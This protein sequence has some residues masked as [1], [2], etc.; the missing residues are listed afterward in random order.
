MKVLKK[1]FIV[2]FVGVLTLVFGNFYTAGAAVADV[3]STD[4]IAAKNAKL[5][6]DKRQLVSNAKVGDKAN[7][8]F[9]TTV[10]SLSQAGKVKFEYDQ[11]VLRIDKKKYKFHNGRTQV[12]VDIDGKDS[13]IQWKHAVGRTDLEVVLPVKFNQAVDH[14][15]L[16]FTVD[17]REVKLPTLTVV[18]KDSKKSKETT[19]P[20]KGKVDGNL[21]DDD[22]VN[23]V[24]AEAE[25]DEAASDQAEAAKQAEDA[26][27]QAEEAK[28]QADAK[29][30]EADKKEEAT[31]Q[32]VAEEPKKEAE[33][34]ENSSQADA[35][36]MPE[37]SD[38]D[39]AKE[40]VKEKR[41]AD[42]KAAEEKSRQA[43]EDAKKTDD[44]SSNNPG[45]N[46][47]MNNNDQTGTNRESQTP[48]APSIANVD[49]AKRAVTG[50][51]STEADPVNGEDEGDDL[52]K[53]LPV[54]QTFDNGMVR[55]ITDEINGS[56][57]PKFFDSITIS[58]KN[59][60]GEPKT[61][62]IDPVLNDTKSLPEILR[63]N[64]NVQI[65]YKWNIAAIEKNTNV[66]TIQNGDYYEFKLK[67]LKY[68]YGSS[69]K[70]DQFIEYQGKT[71]GRVMMKAS[72]DSEDAD[73]DDVQK[74]TIVFLPGELEG[75][76][77][78]WYAANFQTEI[79]ADAEDITFGENVTKDGRIEVEKELINIKKEGEFFK[80]NTSGVT[81]LDKL[82]WTSTFQT[83]DGEK[84]S[85]V[86]LEDTFGEG[87]AK[88]DKEGDAVYTFTVYSSEDDPVEIKKGSD[89]YGYILT[90]D[91]T[92]NKQFMYFKSA[93]LEIK[94]ITKIVVEMQTPTT[95]LTRET[96]KNKIK[97][98][99]A[100]VIDTDKKL[101]TLDTEATISRKNAQLKKT[102]ERDSNGNIK[103]TV[104]FT[105]K[106]GQTNL[107]MTDTLNSTNFKFSSDPNDYKLFR[108]G[109]AQSDWRKDGPTIN[110]QTMTIQF[111]PSI[112]PPNEGGTRTYQLTYLVKPNGSVEDEHY[113]NLSN[114][115]VWNDHQKG[116][117][118]KPT[119]NDKA[120]KEINWQTMMTSWKILVNQSDRPVEN[121]F[122]IKDPQPGE[123]NYLDYKA[124]YDKIAQKNGRLKSEA[125]NYL[126]FFDRDEDK[127]DYEVTKNGDARWKSAGEPFKKA[128]TIRYQNDQI[129]I[130]VDHLPADKKAFSIR[131]IDIPMDKEKI[132]AASN[133]NNEL[134]NI[135][136]TASI[137]Y[138]GIDDG[139][140]SSCQGIP[141]QIKKNITKAGTFSNHFFNDKLIDW[142]TIFNY[143]QYFGNNEKKALVDD[144]IDITDKVG[145]DVIKDA[146]GDLKSKDL[147]KI[148]DVLLDKLE[149]SLNRIGSNGY[150]ISDETKLN[151]NTDY[152][153]RVE[154]NDPKSPQEVQFIL[155]L[156]ED[157]Y[158][159]I[160]QQAGKKVFKLNY[161]SEVTGLGLDDDKT[162]EHLKSWTFNNE[163][164][165]KVDNRGF[166]T[167]ANLSYTDNGYL[168][169]KSGQL[170]KDPITI[171][172]ED[173]ERK[174]SALKW[175]VVINGNSFKLNNPVKIKD[176]IKGGS[177]H[178]LKTTDKN[179]ELKIYEAKKQFVANKSG[180][181]EYVK[182]GDPL[183][184]GTDF[185]VNYSSDLNTMEIEFDG[186]YKVYGPLMI[187]YHTVVD[188]TVG[189][190][191]SNEIE[192][193]LKS[194]DYSQ[195]E[196]V[197]SQGDVSGYF[198]NFAVNIQKRD[199]ITGD[200]LKGVGFQVNRKG[201]SGS[202]VPVSEIRKTDKDGF[203]SFE[204][205]YD[206]AT[207]QVVE[208]SGIEN[209]DGNFISDDFT[210][211]DA[212]GTGNNQST[213]C[214]DVENERT[215]QL[216][217]KKIV[218]NQE[219]VVENDQFSFTVLVNDDNGKLNDNFNGQFNYQVNDGRS[220]MVK[221]V[222]G[223]S[224]G[225]PAI[226]H[227][228]VITITGLPQSQF[229][230][231]IEMKNGSYNTTHKISNVHRVSVN[232]NES[233]ETDTFELDQGQK[234]K[235]GIV[236]FT[237]EYKTTHFS[238]SKKIEGPNVNNEEDKNKQFD[239]KLEVTDQKGNVDEDFTGDIKGLKHSDGS[240]KAM[241]FVFKDG[242]S[243]TMKFDSNG[244]EQAIQLKTGENYNNIQL[245]ADVY[246]KAYEKKDSQYTHTAYKINDDS[247]NEA[248]EDGEYHVVGPISADDKHLKFINEQKENSFEFEK[249]VSGE[250][251]ESIKE[252]T[253]TVEGV[254]K[255]TLNSGIK[256]NEY[257]ALVKNAGSGTTVNNTGKI[258]FDEDGKATRIKYG[259]TD[260]EDIKLEHGQKLVIL[261]LPEK[262][263]KFKVVETTDGKFDTFTHV[264]G[265]PRKEGKDATIELNRPHVQNSILFENINEGYIPLTIKKTISGVVP[266]K[267]EKFEFDVLIKN[268]GQN[269]GSSKEFNAI[270]SD[271]DEEFQLEFKKDGSNYKTTIK[272]EADQSITIYLPKGLNVE[273][274][275]KTEGYDVSHQYGNHKQKGNSHEVELNNND[276]DQPCLPPLI[277][278]NHVPGTV[279]EIEKQVVGN[280]LSQSDYNKAFNFDVM[281][282]DSENKPLTK[283]VQYK[284]EQTNGEVKTGSIKFEEGKV[285][286]VDGKETTRLK[287]KNDQKMT[288]L[289][290]P[291]GA[292]VIITE[293][294]AFGYNPSYIVNGSSEKPGNKADSF[295]TD[296][297]KP[298]KVKFINTKKNVG[299]KISK[300]LAGAGIKESD[301]TKAFDFKIS[302][303]VLNG[304]AKLNGKFSA[305]KY[306]DTGTAKED[307][308]F[309]DGVATDITLK[310]DES[311]EIGG[312]SADYSYIVEEIMLEG[313]EYVVS[314][315]VNGKVE[316]QGN[317]TDPLTIADQTQVTVEF[318]NTRDGAS[319]E[320]AKLL[321]GNG[322]TEKDKDKIFEFQ[323]KTDEKIND[324]LYRA[325]KFDDHGQESSQD[326][327]FENSSS[328]TIKLKAGE[329]LVIYG[330]PTDI[331]YV[332]TETNAAEFETHY[333]MD[334]TGSHEGKETKD[335]KLK[336]DDKTTVLFL[337]SK[338]AS[339]L[340]LTKTLAGD[341]ITEE[342]SDKRFNFTITADS[343]EVNGEYDAVKKTAAGRKEDTKVEFTKGVANVELRDTETLTISGL[344]LDV[345]FTISEDEETAEGFEITHRLNNGQVIKKSETTDFDLR[346]EGAI[347]EFINTK[348]LPETGSLLIQKQLAGSGITEADEDKTFD[349]QVLTDLVGEFKATKVN[350]DGTQTKDIEIE[351]KNGKSNTISLK[352][353]ERLT[354]SGLPLETKFSVIELG[355]TDFQTN[356]L[357]NN[358]KN[359]DGKQ[360]TKFEMMNQETTPV[361]FTNS[362]QAPDTANLKI[363]KK[364]AGD[365][366]TDTDKD[367]VFN[368]RIYSG[369]SGTY[370][371]VKTQ[372]N[373]HTSNTTIN[374]QNG[375]SDVITL[376]ADESLNVT[377]LPI[378][379]TYAVGEQYVGDYAASYK[380]NGSTVT[381]GMT[382][383]FFK[384]IADQNGTVEFTNTKDGDIGMGSF[385]VNKFVNETGDRTRAFNF[386]LEA[387]DGAGN[388]LDG[389]FKTQITTNGGTPTSGMI[390]ITGGNAKF[391]LT[392]G[393]SIKFVLPMGARYEVSE[394]DYTK[395]GY[396]TTVT[397]RGA[398]YTGTHVFGTATGDNDAISYHN[399]IEEDEAELPLPA[400]EDTPDSSATLD[401]P[402]ALP[403]SDG[404]NGTSGSSGTN[405]ITS[406]QGLPSAGYTGK[407]ALPQTGEAND[408]LYTIIGAIA[409]VMLAVIGT[410]YYTKRKNAK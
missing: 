286:A 377:G 85:E 113:L 14:R 186:N 384:M 38:A 190:S 322:I 224:Q 129:I 309:K 91:P 16:T 193:K 33:I 366:L 58:Y 276:C 127:I 386:S 388:P 405:G 175:D 255:E 196:E 294:N 121:G 250:I 199:A 152:T 17:E 407:Q 205:L 26:K 167:T 78:I 261:G 225:L 231:V 43:I 285:A 400:D 260:P 318:I 342:D 369:A 138:E 350:Q 240:D 315:K 180:E 203:V 96:F 311:L 10:G 63:T 367:R 209:Y 370:K 107:T 304:N 222:K 335:F 149:V 268:P 242:V 18:D 86:V 361:L 5:I 204:G 108:D 271:G 214:I 279:V 181:V 47:T 235:I 198:T 306:T 130:H 128:F 177:H 73:R 317:S 28:K 213:F 327:T 381:N 208:V 179:Y 142:T 124:Y 227:N 303:T 332:V 320:I 293:T 151:K 146:A 183:S 27:K 399:D 339:S 265:E 173:H 323:I 356:W 84:A 109:V 379:H 44:Q 35:I 302:A 328:N 374:I 137:D 184:E 187:E 334:D 197:V 212:Q 53:K 50:G 194:D 312:L 48:Q 245:P 140:V 341:G 106:H 308:T 150:S 314:H 221:F 112:V 269:W 233:T 200:P 313:V 280:N 34:D 223:K 398:A 371:A 316:S 333:K 76:A 274:I 297:D 59:A 25:R 82:V 284:L 54:M 234:P 6:D 45:M 275:E 382:T 61:E 301:K 262:A 319:L 229:Y 251:P 157:V 163:V 162:Y 300:T 387:V 120:W 62:P 39:K 295:I 247:E 368:F 40:F 344:P 88:T 148:V 408:K 11:D 238:F 153:I 353:D 389:T 110:G 77:N 123:N 155:K 241:Y 49:G 51:D 56:T 215:S 362:K 65:D 2:Q 170:L 118:F 160:Y 171:Q 264:E 359:Q 176:T 70:F 372:Q 144:G 195:K 329:R 93:E 226:K 189:T 71:I 270:M 246:L 243:D 340:V 15:E 158:N 131:L 402:D 380:V 287:I 168:L 83:K 391:T 122:T 32:P 298:S 330:L 9:D 20:D 360:T 66:E 244:K 406:P 375:Q 80:D 403:A 105:V 154:K 343:P 136:N 385:S 188:N 29:Q 338:Q 292:K 89:K 396:V 3:V 378:E 64:K 263:T 254:D 115:V 337:N 75:Q 114:H 12:V 139:N 409:L 390:N 348:H 354:I 289:G 41:E 324:S 393:Q 383:D 166:K 288:I 272:L 22:L 95:D 159:T 211:K 185:T 104:A 67:G 182:D 267:H 147:Q 351:F 237:N 87:Y 210:I 397:K 37:K 401:E 97:V 7:L 376:R 217:I 325:I 357:V 299:L 218:T 259:E 220:G 68:N 321:D 207:Y 326:V 363:S 13:T 178:H 90:S 282:N 132:Y 404:T 283:E 252:F 72:N 30:K 24:L 145:Q 345:D 36:D 249:S 349:F 236:K 364:L 331:D 135:C 310:G 277:F 202:Y 119:L 60:A 232:G 55:N 100:R 296:E 291:N 133:S 69:G 192:L 164:G 4:E 305:W 373:G 307:V 392:H 101:S 111:K 156:K 79:N 99:S 355:A 165:I 8:A 1:G 206:Q 273:V 228:Q 52:K 94:D 92:D 21:Q 98:Q 42:E 352:S 143:R 358:A 410:I 347:V 161:Q 394:Q 230:Q 395:D 191:Y 266:P 81:D 256:G 74:V 281:A 57:N 117:L 172:E 125:V 278:N 336:K 103:Y 248:K 116:H 46:S 216:Q 102:A 257:T 201:D 23:K 290:L 346:E 19:T 126:Q 219:N 239:F 134:K 169:N 31:E 253:F 141:S 365:G 174:V 258:T